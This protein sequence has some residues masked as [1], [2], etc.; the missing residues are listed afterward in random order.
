MTDRPKFSLRS[1]RV[2]MPSAQLLLVELESAS[3]VL[4]HVGLFCQEIALQFS[5]YFYETEVSDSVVPWAHILHNLFYYVIRR[6]GC[7]CG[8][9]ETSRV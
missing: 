1:S 8:M 6:P 9:F 2:R 3:I 5:V 7:T 4:Q